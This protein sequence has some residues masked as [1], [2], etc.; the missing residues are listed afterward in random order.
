MLEAESQ[1][2]NVPLG[3]LCHQQ[4]PRRNILLDVEKVK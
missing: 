1:T 3:M 2:K 4:L